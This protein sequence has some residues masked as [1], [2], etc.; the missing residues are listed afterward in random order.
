M[1]R[2]T[3]HRILHLLGLLLPS[4][5]PLLAQTTA[6]SPVN[7]PPGSTSWVTDLKQDRQGYL[8][9]ATATGLHRYNGY[10]W[11]SFYQN[12]ASPGDNALESV[13]PTRD[14]LIWVGTR[15][16][17]LDCLDPETGRFRHHRLASRSEPN[18]AENFVTVLREGR[19][20]LLWIGTHNGL[21]S[22][23]PRTGRLTH[24]AHN[25]RDPASL[26]HNQVRAIY[27]DRA[28]TLWV[29]TADPKLTSPDEGGLNRLNR[30]TGRFT[31]YRHDANDANSLIDNRVRTIFE[32]S[33][34]VFWVGTWGDGLHTMDP[35]T[36]R[37][38]RHRYDPAHPERLSRPYLKNQRREAYWG[39]SFVDEDPSGGI[40]IGA[41]AGGLN[42]YDP[43]TG[44]VTH[45]ETGQGP[46][47]GLIANSQWSVCRSRDGVLWVGA[48]SGQL[49][50]IVPANPPIP[51]FG[52]SSAVN[53]FYEYAPGAFWIGT[54]A[55]LLQ[56]EPGSGTVP[57]FFGEA[58]RQTT[59]L[60]DH[61]RAF[62]ADRQGDYWISAWNAGLYQYAVRSGQFTHYRH[63]PARSA[64][65]SSGTISAT[66][67]DRMGTLWVM[68][69]EGLDRFDR[70]TGQFTHFRHN[71]NDSTTLSAGP[72]TVALEDHTGRF[73]VSTYGGGGLNQMDRRTG[74]FTRY[75]S[76]YSIV[77][78]KEDAAGTLWAGA[79]LG[80]LYQ[81][82]RGQNVFRPFLNP[83]SGTPLTGV[84]S[85]VEDN[86]RNLWVATTAGLV[87]INRQR[88]SLNL[89]G[90]TYGFRGAES[91]Y[92]ASAYKSR[93][94]TLLFGGADGYY[95]FRPDELIPARAA[96]PPV[97]FSA[98]RIAN[99]PVGSAPDGPLRG[100]LA[101]A[102]TVYLAH[103]Q[104]AFAVDFAALDY[105]HPERTQ[106]TFFLENYEP[107]WRP[108]GSERTANYYNVPPGQY[109][110]RVKAGSSDGNWTERAMAVVIASPWWQSW[111]AYALLALLTGGSVWG[112]NRYRS[113][114][115]RRENRLLEDKVTLRTEQLQRSLDDL[116]A[117]QTQLVQ[118]EKM[119][120][121]GEL[122]A[123]IAHEIQNPLNFVNNFSQMSV[124][125]VDEL[126]D[127]QGR[128]DRDADLEAELLEDLKLNLQRI[129][130]HGN[131]ASSIV[132]GMLEHSRTSTPDER[133]PINLNA[134]ADEFMRLA[135]HGLR[136][137]D[138]TFN[139]KLITDF[140]SGLGLVEVVP[141]DIG[142]VL[143]NLINNAFNAVREKQKTAAGDY[144]PAVTV[145]TSQAADG[146][147]IYVIDN[148]MGMSEAVKQRLFQ[149]FF[150]TK[151]SG[152]GTGLGLSL[153][154][155]IVTKGHRGQMTVA[156][157][158][159]RGTTFLIRLPTPVTV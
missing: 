5:L 16:L 25:P 48:A 149:P 24:Y 82:D 22:R 44:Q 61:V 98:F 74:K 89:F 70:R 56:R 146:V 154:Y 26:S 72:T 37:F 115:L 80:N 55:G 122:T 30:R 57:A 21:Y 10:E 96:P 142:R 109:I 40:W 45:Y 4:G 131:R 118:K 158:V 120:S 119:A 9:M 68:T 32:D 35:Q 52:A 113:R 90:P 60:T 110:L 71:S 139:A 87:R 99:Q 6:F 83:N 85:F 92:D 69:S 116:K 106:Y 112:F 91:V 152:E 31:R 151:P 67:E 64:S 36:G 47:E 28:G 156:S 132:R 1:A 20:G 43:N 147:E 138:K 59:L 157:E 18:M 148:G 13:C 33:R 65:L 75:L 11:T 133:R 38:T 134:L 125:L 86:V 129:H 95:R 105:R 130:Q 73:W 159:G 124:E 136:S 84:K 8:W 77:Q 140:D 15:T 126:T 108:I 79:F 153:S 121:L 54:H 34:G 76:G 97:V 81:F 7:L 143:L 46:G 3:L 103:D 12:P 104:N 94:G 51:D 102:K 62:Q 63:D 42:R 49:M 150:T 123:G 19:D 114:V 78:V 66:Y 100:P 155:D 107:T 58:S 128:P 39:V 137:K 145:K 111:W 53:T 2:P 144:Q 141:Q 88:D 127:E 50:K 117:T 135:Y 17:G 101:R 27:E 41:Y 23:H 14:G 29:G 93:D